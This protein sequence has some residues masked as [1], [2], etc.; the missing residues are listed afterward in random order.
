MIVVI[1]ALLV[2]AG[3]VSHIAYNGIHRGRHHDEHVG[4]RR[5]RLLRHGEGDPDR[6]AR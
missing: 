2:V 4:R 5:E 3:L 1:L 6:V